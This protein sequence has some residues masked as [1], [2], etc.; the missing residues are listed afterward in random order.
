MTR[1]DKGREQFNISE[2]AGNLAAGGISNAYYP[3]PKRGIGNTMNN[4]GVQV[5]LDAAFNVLKEYWPDIAH[6][7]FHQE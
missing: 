3:A 2:L 7:V 5:G 1:S 4:W 6:K